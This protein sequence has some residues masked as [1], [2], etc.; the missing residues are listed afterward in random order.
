MK[1]FTVLVLASLSLSSFA[2]KKE[3]NFDQMKAKMTE[4]LDKRIA[5]LQSAKSCV[6]SA[7]TKEQLKGCRKNLKSSMKEM[8]GQRKHK[9]DK[10]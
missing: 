7:T 2:Q 8:R 1:L 9:K 4:N 6:S 3:E 5:G 10:K